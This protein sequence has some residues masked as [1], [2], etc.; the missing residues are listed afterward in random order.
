MSS[1]LSQ[2][3]LVDQTI[4]PADGIVDPN[5]P[6]F[7]PA[8]ISLDQA[9]RESVDRLGHSGSHTLAVFVQLVSTGKVKFS[10]RTFTKRLELVD[11]SQVKSRPEAM[12]LVEACLAE[13]RGDDSHHIPEFTQNIIIQAPKPR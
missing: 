3:I 6:D 11:K 10:F 7:K 1:Q 8:R 2:K 9:I 13:L 4:I 5:N 12:I